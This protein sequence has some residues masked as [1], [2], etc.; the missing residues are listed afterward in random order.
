[1]EANN[2]RKQQILK[3]RIQRGSSDVSDYQGLLNYLEEEIQEV[4]DNLKH[5]PD[6]QEHFWEIKWRFRTERAEIQDDCLRQ[7]LTDRS[8]KEGLYIN[9]LKALISLFNGYL[10]TCR[11]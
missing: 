9:Y 11:S 8:Q 5:F 7:M 4:E 10:E 6:L 1:M 3:E 2:T